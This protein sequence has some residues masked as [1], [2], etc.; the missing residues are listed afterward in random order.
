MMGLVCVFDSLF[1]LRWFLGDKMWVLDL[2]KIS[3]NILN[4]L[5]VIF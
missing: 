4:F 2:K 1:F 5:F 3:L